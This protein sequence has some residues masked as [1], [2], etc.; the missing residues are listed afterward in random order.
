M[1]KKHAEQIALEASLHFDHYNGHRLPFA[2]LS[3]KGITQT[4]ASCRVPIQEHSIID[5]SAAYSS[6]TLGAGNQE[7]LQVLAQS[8]SGCVTDELH[9]MARADM[10]VYL[11]GPDG[12][13]TKHFPSGSI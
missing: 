5:L 6:A 4:L 1:D 10:L 9:S 2:C 3:A 13:W 8:T 12:L 11:F 7:L